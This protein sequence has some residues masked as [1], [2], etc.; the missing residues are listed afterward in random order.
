VFRKEQRKINDHYDVAF[1]SEL[2]S[3]VLQ[4]AGDAVDSG[5]TRLETANNWT[6]TVA[7]GIVI[8]IVSAGTFPCPFTG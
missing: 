2:A 8:A 1:S 5:L 4:F 3:G 6:L 7:L